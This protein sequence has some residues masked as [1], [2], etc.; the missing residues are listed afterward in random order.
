MLSDYLERFSRGE[1]LAASRLMSL[2]ERGGTDAEGVLNAIFK[3][4]GRAYRIGV[5]GLT[6]AGKSTLVNALIRYYRKDELTVG[7]V[8]E[9]PT[10]PFSGGAVL[11]DRVRM[12]DAAGDA[13]VFIRSIASRGGET[14]F[15]GSAIELADVLDAFGRDI[16]FLETIGIGQLEYKIRLASDTTIVVLTP[17]AGDDVQSLKSGLME[18][19]DIYV[20]NKA[21]RENA[22]RF[23]NDLRSM[24]E[25]RL[26]EHDWLPPVVSTVASGNDGVD[27]LADAIERHRQHLAE[28]GRFE[29]RRIEGMRQRITVLTEERLRRRFWDGKG[30]VKR[31]EK[32]LSDAL[33]GKCS[34]YEAARNLAGGERG[35]R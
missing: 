32:L 11:G 14:G 26:G 29:L 34:P 3:S 8:A 13:G 31:F 23:A 33:A 27:D 17:D 4:V 28:A 20:V 24:L 22:E 1:V 2:V 19:G 15:S 18:A 25:L 35:D 16:I 21:D 6:G 5:T 7:V 30:V 10:S 12:A 9:D